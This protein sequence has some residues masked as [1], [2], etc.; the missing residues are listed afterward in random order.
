[1]RKEL[2][3]TIRAFNI[4]AKDYQK[5]IAALSNYDQS[6][7]YFF[8]LLHS[9]D[10]I[11]DLGC[12]PANI[13]LQLKKTLPD[14]HIT[15][16][17]L[18]QEMIGLAK[19]NIP[20]GHFLL[21]DAITYKTDK[22]FDS[23]IIGFTLPFLTLSEIDTLFSNT[24]HNLGRSG[25]LYLSFMEGEMVRHERPSFNKSVQIYFHYHNC[26]SIRKKLHDNGFMIVE[27]WSLDYFDS[28][29]SVTKDIVII[30]QKQRSKD[31]IR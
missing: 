19:K 27:E 30:A 17:D 2:K 23:I 29:G 9:S 7:A 15:G 31:A 4:S 14:I 22:P 8:G 26:S 13:S 21:G 28:D 18:S 3:E 5:T 12:G 6:Y 10:T 20:D 16:I 25:Y 1:M 24:N 11:L